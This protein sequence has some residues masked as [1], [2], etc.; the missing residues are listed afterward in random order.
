[1]GMLSNSGASSAAGEILHKVREEIEQAKTDE[2][3]EALERV[4]KVCL[5]ILSAADAGWY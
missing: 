3:R 1:M 2:V 4:A 5:D